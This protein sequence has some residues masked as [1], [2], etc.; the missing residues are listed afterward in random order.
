MSAPRFY[1]PNYQQTKARVINKRD[2]WSCK[3]FVWVDRQGPWGNPFKIG[4]DGDRSAVLTDHE[5]WLRRT[6]ELVQEVYRLHDAALA[7]WCDPQPCHGWLLAFLANC[8][9]EEQFD[10]LLGKPY[11]TEARLRSRSVPGSPGWRVGT[12]LDHTL[13]HL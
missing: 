13:D 5:D 9:W 7:C 2:N 3:A 10:W 6:P 11:W 8:T 4:R 1:T 12:S